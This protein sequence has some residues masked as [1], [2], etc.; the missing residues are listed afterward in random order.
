L[1]ALSRLAE[2]SLLVDRSLEMQSEMGS[3]NI[4]RISASEIH[5]VVQMTLQDIQG[6]AQV[7][8]SKIVEAG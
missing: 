1:Q 8:R 5:V 3:A 2:L 6:R 4:S 7:F